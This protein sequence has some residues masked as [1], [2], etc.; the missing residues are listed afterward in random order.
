VNSVLERVIKNGRIAPAYLF[1]GPPG[2]GK[3]SAALDF[4][5]RLGCK[6]QDR[7]RL[8][9]EGASIKINQILELQ[10]LVR[11]GPSDSPYLVAVVERADEMTTEASGAFLK[12]LEEP[13]PQVVFILIAE[14]EE[15]LPATI[16]SRCQKFLF[17]ERLEDWRP[18]PDLE[19]FYHALQSI[20]G[21]GVME[22]FDFSSRLE[23]ERERIEE[24][25]YGLVFFAKNEA[26]N[27]RWVRILLD[28]IK[29]IKKKA[30]LK[31][32]LDVACLKL[33]EA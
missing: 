16:L 19:Y 25:L 21:R 11:Y 30:S 22:I 27:L 3:T 1:A 5:E 20:K 17:G 28:A 32:A 15:R 14:R 18:D 24:L 31:L 7:I 13:P 2:A 10:R 12:T 6:K 4:S 9:P 33:G 23:K 29:N 26:G 8:G